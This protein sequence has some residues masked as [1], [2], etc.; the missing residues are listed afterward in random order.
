MRHRL[1]PF[2]YAVLLLLVFSATARSGK[3]IRVPQ[4]M[5]SIQ[6]AIDFAQR[7]DTIL[8]SEG[9]YNE[10]I[11]L[12]DEIVL[13]GISSE[14]T[15]IRGQRGKPVVKGAQNAVFRHFTVENGS[16]GIACENV[17]MTIEHCVVRNN[18]E[19]GIQCIIALPII[20]NNV[21]FRNS[22]SGIF[23]ESARS[24]KGVIQNNLIAENGYSGLMLDG[25]SE[26][27]A[28]NNV[29]Y[30]N[31]KYG[32][33]ASGGSRRS[34]IIYNNFFGNRSPA[35]QNPKLDNT[36]LHEDPAFMISEPDANDFWKNESRTLK[37]RGKNGKNIGLVKRVF[38]LPRNENIKVIAPDKKKAGDKKDKEKARPVEVDMLEDG[39]K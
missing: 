2:F 10:S 33:F 20:R 7:G 29:F 26:V 8:V 1:Y 28:E 39:A 16:V 13:I 27:L 35:N 38:Y 25:Q 36:N 14:K 17:F 9:T 34:R 24:H 22:W 23:C 12:R 31:K 15:V 5:N 37:K 11:T 18:K 30:F 19:T 3:L 21:I 32:I 4:R 6:L